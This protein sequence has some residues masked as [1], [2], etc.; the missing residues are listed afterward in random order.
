[1]ND[2]QPGTLPVLEIACD[3]CGGDGGEHWKNGTRLFCTRCGGAG[4]IPTEAGQ[5][6]LSLVQNNL[7]I[8]TPGI[9]WRRHG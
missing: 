5:A 7:R 4:R 3:T 6:V 2:S 1:M 8:E 9:A